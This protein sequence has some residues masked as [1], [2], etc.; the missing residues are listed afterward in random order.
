MDTK[1][2]ENENIHTN[3]NK[4]KC[5]FSFSKMNKYFLIP[6]FLPLFELLL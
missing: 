1:Q 4:K 3:G 2:N 6:F 5:L